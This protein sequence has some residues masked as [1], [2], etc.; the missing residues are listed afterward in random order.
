MAKE[1]G[2]GRPPHGARV[3]EAGTSRGGALHQLP[4]KDALLQAL[5]DQDSEFGGAS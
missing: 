1:P 3:L 5:V 4:G 2:P